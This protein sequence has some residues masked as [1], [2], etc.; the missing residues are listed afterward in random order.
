MSDERER[1]RDRQGGRILLFL[2]CGWLAGAGMNWRE[3]R[4]RDVER[5]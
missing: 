2:A 4:E 3:R 1:R 5:G